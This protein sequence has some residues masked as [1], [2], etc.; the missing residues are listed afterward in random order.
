MYK[1]F[2]YKK[3]N[4]QVSHHVIWSEVSPLY[5]TLILLVEGEQTNKIFYTSVDSSLQWITFWFPM[6]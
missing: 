1:L 6:K 3:G 2:F 5:A 4:N